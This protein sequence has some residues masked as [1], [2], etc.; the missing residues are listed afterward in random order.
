MYLVGEATRRLTHF[1]WKLRDCITPMQKH[2]VYDSLNTI[3][4]S[5]CFHFIILPYVICWRDYFF[6]FFVGQKKKKKKQLNKKKQI[7]DIW[8][9]AAAIE[10]SYQLIAVYFCFHSLSPVTTADTKKK[11]WSKINKIQRLGHFR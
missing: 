10:N 11:K 6:F 9:I 2:C 5:Y 4:L 1:N 3:N 8:C 7:R